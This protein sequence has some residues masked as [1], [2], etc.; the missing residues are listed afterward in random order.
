MASHGRNVR[1]LT[2]APPRSQRSRA[3]RQG[4]LRRLNR[5]A[6]VSV[7]SAAVFGLVGVNLASPNVLFARPV[8]VDEPELAEV[9]TLESQQ[10]AKHDIALALPE[11]ELYDVMK[12]PVPKASVAGWAP[13]AVIPDPGSAQALA[14]QMI[15]ARGWPSTEFD[16]LVALWKKESNWRV[17]A[18]NVSSG[19]YGIPQALPGSK[20]ATAGADWQ[21][22]PATQI[23]WGLG[24]IA[25]RYGSP[26]GAWGHSQARN[27]Y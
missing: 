6:A 11:A 7:A 8:Q 4:V 10:L 24:Y 26:C 12:K 23:T 2:V 27:W 9:V 15:A 17:N 1:Y 19:A 21:T 13:P 25:G 3:P 14:A 16:C 18:M 5:A 20:M 22:N